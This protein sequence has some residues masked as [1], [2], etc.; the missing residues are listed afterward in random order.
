[1]NRRGFLKRMAGAVAVAVGAKAAMA[2]RHG[3]ITTRPSS[4]A[5]GLN[6]DISSPEDERYWVRLDP[7]SGSD[8]TAVVKYVRSADYA[9][10]ENY[11]NPWVWVPLIHPQ[12]RRERET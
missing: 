7:A 2:D 1:M 9:H 3:P 5:C 10:D 6:I 12:P 11:P 8:F 4:K